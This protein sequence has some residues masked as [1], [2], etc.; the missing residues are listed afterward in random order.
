MIISNAGRSYFELLESKVSQAM[1]K[2]GS[3]TPYFLEEDPVISSYELV[4]EVWLA[5]SPIKTA[6]LRHGFSRSRYYE[7]EDRFV[8]YGLAGLFPDIKTLPIPGELERLVVMVAKARPSLSRQAITRIAE[9]VPVTKKAAN[10]E[11]VSQIL[12][13]HGRS[14]SNRPARC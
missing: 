4:R 2:S 6:C 12:A 1:A 7:K 11:S 13:S 5:G 14:L 8:K 3:R 10:I 9:A